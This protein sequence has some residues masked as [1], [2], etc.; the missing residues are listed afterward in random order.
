M[1]TAPLTTIDFNCD[2]GEGCGNDAEILPFISSASLACGLHAGNSSTLRD[3][4]EQCIAAG[5]SIGAHPSYD[6]R[7]HFGRRDLDVAPADVYALTLY[8]VGA[9]AA[10]TRA[11]GGT[12]AH[13]KPHGALYNRAASHALTAGAIARAVRDV[14]PALL[15]FGL[16]ESELTRAGEALGLSVVHEVFAERR[17]ESNGRLTPRSEHGAVLASVAESLDQ[18][19]QL[20]QRR[21]VTARSG[22]TIAL[23]ADS[24][25]LHGDRDDA[26]DFA[27]QVRALLSELGIAVQAPTRAHA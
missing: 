18:V 26:V 1:M 16:A 13:V 23:R 21:S 19:R 8:Q 25:C 15:L 24:L 17:Y 22:E 3:A 12:L 5:V 7:E 6:D 4:I 14:D 11:L 20:T 2:L 9:A 10:M 27:R